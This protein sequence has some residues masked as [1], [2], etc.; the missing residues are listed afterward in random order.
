MKKKIKAGVAALLAMFF[1]FAG[2]EAMAQ[3]E[4]IVVAFTLNGKVVNQKE[5]HRIKDLKGAASF[6]TSEEVE[7]INVYHVRGVMPLKVM[8]Y[9][10]IKDFQKLDLAAWALTGTNGKTN[11]SID[12]KAMA[13]RSGDRIAME[14]IF[15]NGKSG[16]VNLCLK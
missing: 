5:C 10:E 7:K 4:P 8:S 1:L 14:V 2:V 3:E 12:P 11:S 6:S 15:K 16:T 9:N 13:A